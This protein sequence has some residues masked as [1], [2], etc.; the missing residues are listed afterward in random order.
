MKSIF[1]LLLV[2]SLFV[3]VAVAQNAP[4][5]RTDV[6]HVH[7]AAAAPGK[8]AALGEYLSKPQGDSPMAGHLVVLRH[9]DGAEWDYV[10]ITHLGT[11][12]TVEASTP[13]PPADVQSL[14]AWHSDTFVNGPA[15]PD[16]VRAMGIGD[17][18]AKTSGSVYVV[19]V[20]RA[21]GGHRSELEKMLSGPPP[22]GDSSVGNVLMAHLEGSPWQF[23]GIVRYNSWHDF[24]TGE[25]TA[26]AQMK[27]G[28]GGWYTLREH[29]SYHTDTLTDRLAP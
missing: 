17:D 18:S 24:A 10:A 13:P 5:A 6:Y 2:L 23:L 16:F 14:Y 3:S 26:V 25:T 22:G 15:W 28:S 20:Y 7:F 9:Q 29:A 4:A 11:K 27:K 12:A 8:A 19:S 1:N 21:I